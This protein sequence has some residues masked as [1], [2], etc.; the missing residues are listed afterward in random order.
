MMLAHVIG[1][2]S[3]AVVELDQPQAVFILLGERKGPRSFWSKTPNCMSP[4]ET[5]HDPQ[6]IR[7]RIS[8]GR[9]VGTSARFGG[10]R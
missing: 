9:S 10:L 8:R 4:P 1:A 3:G 5:L 2:E 6:G 7:G